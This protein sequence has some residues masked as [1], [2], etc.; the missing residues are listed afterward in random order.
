MTWSPLP[1]SAQD[2]AL[3]VLLDGPLPRSE[4]ARRLR[5]SAGSLTRLTKPLVA[6]G[7]L[8]EMPVEHDPVTGRPNR[9]LDI[10]P[11]AHHF[12][13]VKLTADTAH[14]VLTS[15]RAEVLARG[16]R[17]LP[18]RD[19]RT[20]VAVVAELAR[21]LGAGRAGP[22]AAGVSLGGQVVDHS[23]VVGARFLGWRDVAL[24]AACEAAL[25]CPVVVDNDLLS[26]TRAEQWFGAG[27]G[28]DDFALLTVGE[29]I[30]Y[31]LVVS[32]R[33]RSG[34]DASVGVLGHHPLDPLGPLCPEGHQGCAEAM[35]TIPAI[36]HRVSLGLGRDVGYDTCLDLAA[37]GDPVAA[38][39]VGDAAAALGRLTAAVGNITMTDRVVLSGDGIRLADVGRTAFDT[40]LR[41]GRSPHASPLDVVVQRTDF[42]DWARGAAATAIQT[43]VL[44]GLS[45]DRP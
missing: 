11:A 1:G 35:L 30:G 40:A 23:T 9:P 26:L 3:A 28:Y 16:R 31:G 18:D 22:T 34:P 37:S 32:G 15:L 33:I 42:T 14:G 4:L 29:G 2:V 44:G 19:P 24:G 5:L 36:R 38:R 27:K 43:Y 13:G 25:G 21:E 20:V 10:R 7:L 12:L 41:E 39:A 17:A 45:P 6:D 8:V